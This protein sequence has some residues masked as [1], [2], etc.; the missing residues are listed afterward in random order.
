MPLSNLGDTSQL[1]ACQMRP[2]ICRERKEKNSLRND[3]KSW[4]FHRFKGTFCIRDRGNSWG[5][6]CILCCKDTLDLY[7]IKRNL[8]IL[9][10]AQHTANSLCCNPLTQVVLWEECETQQSCKYVNSCNKGEKIM[11][12]K[13]RERSTKT[14]NPE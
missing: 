5:Y 6:F 4:L 10:L 14:I 3:I 7:L 1:D 11:R 12:E 9:K 13:I 2:L 8:H